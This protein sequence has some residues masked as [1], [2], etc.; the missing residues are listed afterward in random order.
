[1]GSALAAAKA[2]LVTS[3]YFAGSVASFNALVLLT[4]KSQVIAILT[5]NYTNCAGGGPATQVGSAEYCFTALFTGSVLLFFAQLLLISFFFAIAYGLF[6]EILPGGYS[7]GK[8]SLL[9]SLIMLV[10]VLFTITP[11]VGNLEQLVI[12]VG[13]E[14]ALALVMALVQARLY[15]RFTREVEFQTP[16]P[17]IKILVGKRNQ[18]GKKRTYAIGSTQ[19]VEAAGEGRQFKGW[20]VSGGVTVDD[21][22]SPTTKIH[23]TGDGLLKATTS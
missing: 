17:A 8:K 15:R 10:A 23:V 12:V 20:L 5:Q 13:A 4:F 3:I 16:D 11:V 2:G 14:V 22:R 6:F 21:A 1:L 18:A 7:Y 19:S 9:M